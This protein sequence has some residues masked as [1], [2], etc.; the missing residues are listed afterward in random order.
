[1]NRVKN[2]MCR[3]TDI[4]KHAV[5][6]DNY[7]MMNASYNKQI[8]SDKTIC[9]VLSHLGCMLGIKL[10]WNYKY[11]SQWH[12]YIY[13]CHQINSAV[14]EITSLHVKSNLTLPQYQITANGIYIERLLNPRWKLKNDNILYEVR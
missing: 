2:K 8:F 1:M 5:A 14:S 7:T 12:K 9:E 3:R 4:A 10:R 13:L 11:D 6:L